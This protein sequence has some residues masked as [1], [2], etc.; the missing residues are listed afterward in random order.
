MHVAGRS[1]ASTG[2]APVGG[3]DEGEI[4][5]PHVEFVQDR[6]SKQPFDPALK[7]NARIKAE[8]MKLGL[9]CY[10]MGGTLDGVRGDHVLIAPPYIVSEAQLDELADKLGRAVDA[11]FRQA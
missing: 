4:G 6:A 1:P 5:V 10:P 2:G 9:L 3:V 8:A 11:A 7:I